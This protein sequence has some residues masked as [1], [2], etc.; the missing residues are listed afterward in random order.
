MQIEAGPAN[1]TPSGYG[2]PG[3]F[4]NSVGAGGAAPMELPKAIVRIGEQSLWSAYLWA[5]ATTLATR[6]GKV[7]TTAVGGSGQGFSS[8][9]SLAETNLQEAGRVP[10]GYSFAVAGIA[11]QWFRSTTADSTASPT[12]LGNDVRQILANAVLQWAF[13]QSRIEIAP[14][15]LIGA[16][17]GAF[18]MTADT[19]DAEGNRSQVTVGNGQVWIYQNSPVL[20]PS[21]TTFGVEVQ[22]GSLAG[23]FATSGS[24]GVISR[25]CLLGQFTSAIPTA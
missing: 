1:Y 25:V 9:L 15:Y 7:F 19:G 4:V 24:S 12:F 13:L 23:Q 6:S 10:S 11:C 21:S 2:F 22:W 5:A 3:G 20:L 18:G 8:P 17:G 14:A 16:G